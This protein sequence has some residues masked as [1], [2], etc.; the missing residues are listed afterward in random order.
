MSTAFDH[1]MHLRVGK[2]LQSSTTIC[3]NAKMTITHFLITY[4]MSSMVHM[5][6]VEPVFHYNLVP[7]FIIEFSAGTNGGVTDLG[8]RLEHVH[9]SDTIAKIVMTPWG[10]RSM[11]LNLRVGN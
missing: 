7:T 5:A 6:M 10:N 3:A 4:F 8:T 11:G 1:S 9:S 2:K